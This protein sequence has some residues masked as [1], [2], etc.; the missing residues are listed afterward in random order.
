MSSSTSNSNPATVPKV[1]LTLFVLLLVLEIFTRVKL[2]KMSKDFV[3]FAGYSDRARHLVDHK[4]F[5]VAFIGNSSTERGVNLPIFEQQIGSMSGLPLH[6]D[7]FVADASKV[8]TWY[9]MLNRYFWKPNLHPDLIV[10][11][12]YQHNLADGNDIE[13][14]RMAQFFTQPDDWGAVFRVDLKEPSERTEFILSSFWATCAGRER[15]KERILQGITPGY[16]A[17]MQEVNGINNIM[18]LRQV[19]TGMSQHDVTHQALQRLLLAA[20]QHNTRLCFVAFPVLID[21]KQNSYELNAEELRLIRQNNMYF[22]D[23]RITKGI[24]KAQ[25][26]DEIHLTSEGA[27]IY[28]HELALRL[29]TILQQCQRT[30]KPDALDA[31]K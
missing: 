16:K 27:A 19:R 4:G 3:R 24:N 26:S 11:S 10:L 6:T 31:A 30:A 21:A 14:G 15:I 28:T 18:R 25:Y 12:Y 22:V 2:F 17:Y 20:T 9:F 7:M 5:R 1:L 29:A 8:N 13:I 23:M